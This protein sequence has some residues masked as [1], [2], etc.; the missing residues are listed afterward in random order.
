[1]NSLWKNEPL[2]M[3]A[4]NLSNMVWEQV[5]LNSVS[6]T[7]T[8]PAARAPANCEI[9][10]SNTGQCSG[11]KAHSY[12]RSI[13]LSLTLIGS[14]TL[15]AHTNTSYPKKKFCTS[16]ILWR[17]AL[18]R[19][20]ICAGGALGRRVA[21]TR[22]NLGA[23]PNEVIALHAANVRNPGPMP[24][25]PFPVGRGFLGPYIAV[26]PIHRSSCACRRTQPPFTQGDLT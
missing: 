4:P 15:P 23:R 19:M 20:A 24:I 6:L 13:R 22:A 16:T 3:N 9:S 5:Q 18:A 14:C 21:H 12:I 26:S 8:I 2:S 25:A 1:M 17:R 7:A 10:S 11:T